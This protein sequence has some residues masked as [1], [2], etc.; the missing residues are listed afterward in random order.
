MNHV[1]VVDPIT[2]AQNL[3]EPC[4]HCQSKTGHY[5][6]CRTINGTVQEVYS[7]PFRTGDDIH[8]RGLGVKWS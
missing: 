2:N 7:A 4:P 3:G 6:H 8:L 5:N 1:E